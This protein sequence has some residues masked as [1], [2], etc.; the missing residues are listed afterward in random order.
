[1][2]FPIKLLKIDKSATDYCPV[3]L[4]D[5]KTL[6][7]LDSDFA[8]NQ[9]NQSFVNDFYRGFLAEISFETWAYSAYDSPNKTY[10]SEVS[11]EGMV[12]L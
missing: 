5:N 10:K 6:Q 3:S 9:I 4:N 7:F 8:N 11:A 1:M 12:F 2:L